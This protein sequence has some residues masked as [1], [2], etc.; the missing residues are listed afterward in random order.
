[1]VEKDKLRERGREERAEKYNIILLYN[2]LPVCTGLSKILLC[3]V[4]WLEF[5]C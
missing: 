5:L 3:F 4:L 1:M 2:P